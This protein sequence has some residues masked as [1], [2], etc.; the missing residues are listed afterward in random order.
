MKNAMEKES[1]RIVITDGKQVA[2]TVNRGNGKIKMVG[3]RIEKWQNPREAAVIEIAQ[4]TVGRAGIVDANTLQELPKQVDSENSA[5][6][7]LLRVTSDL[8]NEIA[9]EGG[10]DAERIFLS[11]IG[12]VEN[13]LYYPFWKVWWKELGEPTVARLIN[14]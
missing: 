5:H 3:G 2:L 10:D 6:W 7:F 13:H 8:L 9:G 4:E 11:P 14:G 12:D 1:A